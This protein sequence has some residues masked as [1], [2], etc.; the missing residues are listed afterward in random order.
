MSSPNAAGGISLL[1]SRLRKEGIPITPVRIRRA[2]E[3]TATPVAD[4]DPLTL[5]HGLIN[6]QG[7]FNTLLTVATLECPCV[8]SL[9]L[10]FF[11]FVAA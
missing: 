2:L 10:I 1:V 7:A 8:N 11:D 3:N 9:V 5:G 4:V 6:I